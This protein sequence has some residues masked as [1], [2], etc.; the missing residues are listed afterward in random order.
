MIHPVLPLVW[1]AASV[2]MALARIRIPPSPAAGLAGVLSSN[3]PGSPPAVSETV[4]YAAGVVAAASH[5]VVSHYHSDVE[6]E[7]GTRGQT[8]LVEPD[9]R[10]GETGRM[11]L[12]EDL[13]PLLQLQLMI[14]TPVGLH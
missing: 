9:P 12:V 13:S 8:L 5:D 10:L 11:R 3:L 4:V 1:L 14:P 7:V 6:N 2:W